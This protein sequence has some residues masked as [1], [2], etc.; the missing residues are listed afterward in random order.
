MKEPTLKQPLRSQPD[1]GECHGPSEEQPSFC[2]AVPRGDDTQKESGMSQRQLAQ[3]L[4]KLARRH[5]A[6]R[7]DLT[8]VYQGMQKKARL[9]LLTD[10]AL[11]GLAQGVAA[12]VSA[13]STHGLQLGGLKPARKDSKNMSA[14][15]SVKASGALGTIPV[16]ITASLK[17]GSVEVAFLK[18]QLYPIAKGKLENVDAVLRI[19]FQWLA[20]ELYE[21]GSGDEVSS[22]F[23]VAKRSIFLK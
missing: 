23:L 18:N 6:L 13:T 20:A 11:D 17:D 16:Y 21:I 10:P 15:V 19:A 3:T 9:S 8:M 14:G 22:S 2:A 4:K 5:P 12:V 1:Y 7:N